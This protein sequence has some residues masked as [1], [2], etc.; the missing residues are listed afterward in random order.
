MAW[1]RRSTTTYT[2]IDVDLDG[3]D[4]EQLLQ[5]LIDSHVLTEAEAEMIAARKP[6]AAANTLV[7][8]EPDELSEARWHL[9]GGRKGEAVIHLERYLGREW[10]GVLS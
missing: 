6:G 3:F 9:A 10:L 5:G 1:K 8:G 2:S 4:V 7:L